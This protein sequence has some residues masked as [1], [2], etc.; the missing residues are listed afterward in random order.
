MESAVTV[1]T[2]LQHQRGEFA[3][4]ILKNNHGQKAAPTI[5]KNVFIL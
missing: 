2:Q 3:F 4:T 1:M 5:F